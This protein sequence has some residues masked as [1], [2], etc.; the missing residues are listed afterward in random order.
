MTMY[1]VDVTGMS[2]GRVYKIATQIRKKFPRLTEG[3]R[4]NCYDSLMSSVY[5]FKTLCWG[6]WGTFLGWG[7]NP[8]DYPVKYRI[9]C[10]NL[11]RM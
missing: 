3:Y 10:N 8:K 1:Y 4:Y 5:Q 7:G 6:D 2:Q 11:G 9:G